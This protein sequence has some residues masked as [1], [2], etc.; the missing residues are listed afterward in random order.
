VDLALDA[1]VQAASPFDAT[2][3]VRAQATSLDP[4]LRAAYP[5]LPA[6]LGIVASGEVR[7]EGALR[8][9]ESLIADG[10]LDAFEVQVPEYPARAPEPLRFRVD[11]GILTV[12]A[13]TLAAEGTDLRL[14]GRADLLGDGPLDLSL[15]GAA[16]LR[17]L[18]VLLH[19]M[20][21]TGSA[22]LALAVS[23]TRRAPHAEGTLE[24]EGA[25]LRVRG[26]P[27]GL[28]E[29]RGTVRFTEAGATLEAFKGRLAGG[30]VVVEGQAAFTA[31]RI[32]SFDV[33][34]RGQGFALRWPEGVR[35]VV[36]AD[37]RFFGDA[38]RSFLTGRVDVRQAVYGKRYDL[39]SEI[40]AV[41]AAERRAG[42]EGAGPNLDVRVVAP[43]TL[44]V[45]N[46]LAS[47]TAR[48]DLAL[49]G[50]TSAPIVLGRA[51]VDRGRI[52]FQ[53]RTYVIRHGAIDFAN[54]SELDP[55]FDIE[56]ETRLPS[57][58]V[59]LRLNGTLERVSSTLTSD[60]PLSALQIL[61][62]LAGADERTVASMTAAQS[63]EAQLAATGAATLAAGKISEEVGLERGAERLLG[64]DR[65]SIDPSL[66][67]GN[68]QTP[69]ARV[70]V[71]KRLT[72]GLNVVYSQ[73]LGG[74]GQRL[75]AVEYI[76]S[77]RFSLL[78][79]RSDPDGFGF[80]VRLRRSR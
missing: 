13:F 20:R 62:L 41:R 3:K 11:G 9:P 1:D 52:Y 67:R 38:E 55:L 68:G 66:L 69:T 19:P 65:F 57:Y 70:T 60:P 8:D 46:N 26:F 16:D 30:E 12:D 39:A 32:S 79:T 31:G 43:G 45:D 48:A 4:F 27:H 33:R 64:L 75:V 22:R 2:M 47:L 37:L 44:R 23:G 59:T 78:L 15:R 53:G 29:A 80:D 40:L 56:A 42:A 35:S 14:A 6:G 34:P 28:E 54:P 21:G 76:L 77:D 18:S 17:A 7:L 72:S 25:G 50:T 36:D 71:G 51:E 73:D 5:P 63:N 61:N 10:Q 74:P 49:R 58:R 24:I